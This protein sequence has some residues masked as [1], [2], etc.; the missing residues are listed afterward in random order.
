MGSRGLEPLTPGVVRRDL[1]YEEKTRLHVT[2]ARA[3][4]AIHGSV[5]RSSTAPYRTSV[6]CDTFIATGPGL[7]HPPQTF[8][9][10]MVSFASTPSTLT[11][12]P[13]F[14]PVGYGKNPRNRNRN[15]SFF[16]E[17][18]TGEVFP[19]PAGNI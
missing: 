13:L 10:L 18:S 5:L 16:G 1:F 12:E 4:C 9:G 6:R 11:A 8:T 17:K 19:R 15:G 2:G 14:Y 3:S 7:L